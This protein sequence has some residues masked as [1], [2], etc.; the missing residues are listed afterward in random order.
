MDK[1]TKTVKPK[2]LLLKSYALLIFFKA[3]PE[4]FLAVINRALI[5]VRVVHIEFGILHEVIIREFD[6]VKVTVLKHQVI[7]PQ[8][9]RGHQCEHGYSSK[10]HQAFNQFSHIYYILASH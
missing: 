7:L 3:G 2:W 5:S 4:Q 8:A 9:P 1:L 6:P 10:C